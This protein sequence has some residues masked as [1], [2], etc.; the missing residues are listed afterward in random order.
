MAHTF[1]NVSEPQ[2]H[3]FQCLG[4]RY[5]ANT[6]FATVFATGRAPNKYWWD[7]CTQVPATSQGC[8][9][10]KTHGCKADLKTSQ[11]G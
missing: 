8:F 6:A 7:S 9:R 1:S 10:H 11:L 5:S 4:A 3:D 2:I